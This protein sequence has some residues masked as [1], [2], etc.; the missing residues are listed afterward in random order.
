MLTDLSRQSGAEA[1]MTLPIEIGSASNGIDMSIGIDRDEHEDFSFDPGLPSEP[2]EAELE[3][4]AAPGPADSSDPV[5]TYLREMGTVRLL[6]REAEVALAKQIERGEALVLKAISR[7]PIAIRELI[8]AGDDLR[9]GSRSV[10]EIVYFPNEGHRRT[11]LE[12]RRVLETI[13]QI[14]D[15]FALA[16]RQAEKVA[17]PRKAKTASSVRARWQLART[18][19]RLSQ[20]VRSIHFAEAERKHLLSAVRAGTDRALTDARAKRPKSPPAYENSNAADRLYGVSALELSRTLHL[21]RKGEAESEQGRRALIEANLRLVVSIAKRY[22]N[23]GLQFLDLIQEG[24]LGL[25][26]AVEKFEWRRGFKFSTYA[27]WWI[28]QAV[29]RAIADRARTIRVPVHMIEA[30]NRMARTR[31]EMLRDLGREPSTEELAKKLG[32]SHAKVRELVKIAQEPISLE[33]PVGTDQESH[34]GDL[35]EDRSV[36]SPADAMIDVSMKEQTGLMLE[37]LTPREAQ[38]LRMRFGLE[39]GTEHTLEDVGRA[40]GLTRERIRQIEGEAMRRLRGAASTQR[41][42]S[43]LRRAS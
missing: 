3:V 28:R 15:L 29:S 23:R 1:L 25:M 34:L 24:N 38:I 14:S 37:T 35:I 7:S 5:R 32:L 21:I 19:V 12:T 27:T 43:Y 22:A 39:D 13:G 26:R 36:V 20:M 4:E 33:T 10:N 17:A 6:K 41:L 40:F 18:R 31:R 9:R 30:I 8:A 16:T 2:E 11:E 42:H